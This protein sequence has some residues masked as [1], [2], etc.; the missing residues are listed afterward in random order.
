[1]NEAELVSVIKQIAQQQ[2]QEFRPF[3]Y[4][5][6]AKYDPKLHRV[7]VVVPTYA[8]EDGG[9][10]M[11]PWM[12]LAS[13]SVGENFGLQIAPIG[14]ATIQDPL[15]GEAVI[16][17]MIGRSRGIV[18]AA[19]MIF[20]N[21]EKVPE[22]ELKPGEVIL[23]TKSKSYI[24]FD[25]HGAVTIDNHEEGK[26]TLNIK[27]DIKI[28]SIDGKLTV[29]IKDD[30]KVESKDGKLTLIIK[31]DVSLTTE[32]KVDVQA[33]GDVSVKTDGEAK[34]EAGGDVL[35]K[36]GGTLNLGDVGGK[37]IVLDGDPVSGGQVHA[38]ST[39]VKAM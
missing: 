4:G 33:T 38:T 22:A 3:A 28:D 35:V 16:I 6:I 19:T 17:H 5:H 37:K 20:N 13:M 12:P 9:Y 32:G 21:V 15:K 25:E 26:L 27:D 18:A 31:G 30:I 7:Q 23:K 39:K 11:S 2:V 1:M 24:K 14:G 34:V 29:T 8:N 36:T 10:V